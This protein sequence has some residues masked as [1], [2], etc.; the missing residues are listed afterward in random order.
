MCKPANQVTISCA[1]VDFCRVAT[2]IATFRTI[3]RKSIG[4]RM[5]HASRLLSGFPLIVCLACGNGHRPPVSPT[6]KVYAQPG[7]TVK[8]VVDGLPPTGGTVILGIGT[9]PSG[10]NSDFISRPNITI[11]GSGNPS[12]NSTFTA[13]TGGTIVVGTLAASS[14]ADNFTM[15][16]LGVDVG[17]AYVDAN[18]GGVPL[19]GVAIFNNGEV[20][21]APQVQS[22]TVENVSCLG[23]SAL[24][25]VHCMLVENVNH[26]TILNV[27]TALN[28]HGL[29]LKGTDSTVNGVYAR[30]HGIDSVILK[31]DNYAPTRSDW[32]TNITVHYLLTP[33]DTKGIILK[34][35]ESDINNIYVSNVEIIGTLG[36]GIRVVGPASRAAASAINVSNVTV[37][38]PGGSPATDY[39]MEFV[40]YVTDVKIAG[41]NCSNMWAGIAP[42]SPSVGIFTINCSQFRN[43]A[44]TAIETYG[45]WNISNTT[46]DSVGGSAILNNFGVTSLSGDI[47]TGIGGSDWEAAGGTF[48]FSPATNGC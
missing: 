19:N 34:G 21:G 42:Y 31:S 4:D 18:N 8:E 48:A 41:L 23:Y 44:T 20:I 40:Q 15:R 11:Q 1:G 13:M 14:G 39:C 12:Y 2:L 5:R 27:T 24:A 47:F 22:P 30:G 9:W 10:Y 45:N 38:Y 29:V 25:P 37:D 32:L 26:A 7:Q 3:L 46:F 6:L 28:Q 16:D 35:A 43:I 36:W 33:G 17:S